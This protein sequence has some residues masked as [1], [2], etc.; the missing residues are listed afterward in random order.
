MLKVFVFL[1]LKKSAAEMCSIFL[2][3]LKF[4]TVLLEK[5]ILYRV[6]HYF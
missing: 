6:E 2:L 4:L 1:W 3:L 5:F